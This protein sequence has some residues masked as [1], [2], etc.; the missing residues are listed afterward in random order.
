M[1]PDTIQKRVPH[2]NYGDSFEDEYDLSKLSDVVP[3]GRTFSMFVQQSRAP[4]LEDGS[5][6]PFTSDLLASVVGRAR[7]FV[8]VGAHCG[9]Y[10]LL[11]GTGNPEM[12]IISLEPVPEN[13]A[14][15]NKKH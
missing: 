8:D 3:R 2:M 7:L 6:E 13:F 4:M 15:L 12:E 5:F 9:F 10:T 1:I 14:I 11:V